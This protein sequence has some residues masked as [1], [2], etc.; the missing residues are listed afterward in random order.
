MAATASSH[1]AEYYSSLPLSS[2]DRCIRI[3][4]L[5]AAPS[6]SAP[7][8]GSLR[9]VSLRT[10]PRFATLSYVWGP[11]AAERDVI[12]CR[13]ADPGSACRIDITANCDAA[14]RQLRDLF[15]CLSIWVDAV[16]INQDDIAEK[17]TQIPM[18]EEIYTWAA[19]AYIWL[20]PG[21][22]ASD[23]VMD[24]F[25]RLTEYRGSIRPDVECWRAT[26]WIEAL[27]MRAKLLLYRIMVQ[28]KTGCK[29]S[30]S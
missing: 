12:I 23:E 19:P 29:L 27:S 30:H 2:K 5:D 16:C 15:G 18:M 17:E 26:G 24:W 28:H 7:L 6:S 22:A 10:H 11:Y 8:T 14:L 9:V 3:L 21:T 1:T 4:D 13:N 20:G 25:S